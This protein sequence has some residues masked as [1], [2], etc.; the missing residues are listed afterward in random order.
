M[1]VLEDWSDLNMMRFP[2]NV[3]AAVTIASLRQSDAL[4]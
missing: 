1:T 3:G 4:I 2:G